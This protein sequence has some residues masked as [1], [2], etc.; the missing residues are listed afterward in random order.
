[1][2]KFIDLTDWFFLG[3]TT[4]VYQP[5]VGDDKNVQKGKRTHRQTMKQAYARERQ[6]DRQ[7]DRLCR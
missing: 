2:R 7:R 4:L 3:N 1:M 5:S 6:R